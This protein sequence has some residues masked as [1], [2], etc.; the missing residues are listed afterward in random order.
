MTAIDFSSTVVNADAICL[1]A[2]ELER[3][4]RADDFD[5]TARQR[6]RLLDLRN[7]LN[8]INSNSLAA[9]LVG[10]KAT[11]ISP[12][13]IKELSARV[14]G[15]FKPPSAGIEVLSLLIKI[16]ARGNQEG[17]FLVC[18]PPLPVLLKKPPSP[19]RTDL[20]G[21][22]EIARKLRSILAEATQLGKDAPH[23]DV[24]SALGQIL[25]SAIVH[26]GLVTTASLVAL[27]KAL[28][29]RQ[30]P[31]ENLGNRL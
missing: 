6:G 4:W 24:R 19:F 10:K 27:L 8:R 22:A 21:A 31:L 25:L 15:R 9:L 30:S 17:T 3:L 28:C 1:E 18:P 26:G 16:I 5:I 12:T 2:N 23:A 14:I 29:G 11:E 7:F 13:C 20:W